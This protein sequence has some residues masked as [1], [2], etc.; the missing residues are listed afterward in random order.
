MTILLLNNARVKDGQ[1]GFGIPT[2]G[3]WPQNQNPN[4][5]DNFQSN[6]THQNYGGATYQDQS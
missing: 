5:S 1:T 2:F 6:N 3:N 4:Y